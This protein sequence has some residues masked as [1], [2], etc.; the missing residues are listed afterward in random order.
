MISMNE[1]RNIGGKDLKILKKIVKNKGCDGIS[2]K[3]DN[4]IFN[5]FDIG[6]CQNKCYSYAKEVLSS[7]D[8]IEKKSCF[9]CMYVNKIML[10][11]GRKIVD[12]CFKQVS[13]NVTNDTICD[14]HEFNPKEKENNF[15]IL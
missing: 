11:D 5:N 3:D 10:P 13:G 4:C 15:R 9:T 14:L 7:L 2:C 6:D 1:F 8:S 12:R